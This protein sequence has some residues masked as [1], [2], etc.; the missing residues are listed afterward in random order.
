MNKENIP[1]PNLCN[2]SYTVNHVTNLQ[3]VSN[4][5]ENRLN[6]REGIYHYT[7]FVLKLST[8]WV[9]LQ[10]HSAVSAPSMANCITHSMNK[11]A[12]ILIITCKSNWIQW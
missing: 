9:K 1:C 10:T 2:I 7:I 3:K 11:Q 8:C 5:D 12:I 4:Y 6:V